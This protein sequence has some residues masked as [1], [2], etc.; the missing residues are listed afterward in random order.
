MPPAAMHLGP[1][2]QNAS[3][4]DLL[5]LVIGMGSPAV[6]LAYLRDRC[7]PTSVGGRV[8]LIAL[9]VGVLLAVLVMIGVAFEVAGAEPAGWLVRFATVCAGSAGLAAALGTADVLR[10]AREATRGRDQGYADPPP[11]DGG[12]RRKGRR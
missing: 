5:A 4:L 12:R 2:F 8:G 11:P 1:I 6:V 7:A 3:W 9:A 10:S